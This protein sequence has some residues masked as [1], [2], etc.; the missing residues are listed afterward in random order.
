MWNASITSQTY[1]AGLNIWDNVLIWEW[2][3]FNALNWITIGNNCMIANY[4][5]FLST[6]HETKDLTIPIYKQWYTIGAEQRI[7]IWDDVW[8]GFN[9][10]IMKWVSIWKGAIIWAGA[11]VTKDVPENAIVGWVPAK[12][13]K[14]RG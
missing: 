7:I 8:I 1:F 9:A 13:I 12:I 14:Y 6:D 10:V 4:C 2:G 5:A 3:L 11:V